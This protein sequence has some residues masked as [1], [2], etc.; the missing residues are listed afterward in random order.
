[1][2]YD[3]LPEIDQHNL[4]ALNSYADGTVILDDQS[5]EK[6]Q[7]LQFATWEEQKRLG[8]PWLVSDLITMGAAIN[9]VDYFMVTSET[10]HNLIEQ[11]ELPVSP[12]VLDPDDHAFFYSSYPPYQVGNE[13]RQVHLLH[14]GALFAVIRWTN[15]FYSSDFVGG[16]MQRIF[17]KG[18]KDICIP[19]KSPWFYPGGHTCYWDK[20]DKNNA[21]KEIVAALRLPDAIPIANPP[22]Q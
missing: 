16:P 1:V 22:A 4:Q 14:H 13:E 19:R 9:A 21:L 8:N 6:Y 10:I 7:E 2:I 11:R 12:P 17:G 18:I 15:I 3:K 20:T 5:L